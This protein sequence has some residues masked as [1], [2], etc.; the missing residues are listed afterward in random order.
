MST[1]PQTYTFL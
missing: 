1:K